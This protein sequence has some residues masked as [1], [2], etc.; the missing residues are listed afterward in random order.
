[1]LSTRPPPVELDDRNAIQLVPHGV[2]DAALDEQTVTVGQ[3]SAAQVDS[4]R[5]PGDGIDPEQKAGLRL[6]D[7]QSLAVRGERDAVRVESR[8]LHP[9][10]RQRN[11]PDRR[12]RSEATAAR[13]RHPVE[14]RRL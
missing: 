2:E 4:S 14:L 11:R 8:P 7:E 12:L 1:L 5:H 10:A 3:Q 13:E 9:V 6:H